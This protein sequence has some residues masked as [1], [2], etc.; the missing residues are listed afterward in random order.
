MR[1]KAPPRIATGRATPSL[2]GWA[3]AR[4][5]TSLRS[6]RKLDCAA[7]CPR[8]S[9][10]FSKS[11]RDVTHAPT[12]ISGQNSP[13]DIT[14][15]A[16]VRPVANLRDM[17]MLDG[18]EMNV[19]DVSLQVG[20][21]A[22]GVLPIPALPNS[23]LPARSLAGAALHLARESPRKSSLDQAPAQR[24]IRIARRQRPNGVKVV[25]QYAN[26]NRLEWL[27]FSNRRVDAP[28]PTDVPNENVARS[29]G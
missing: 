26:R 16:A 20:I 7:P 25:R 2:V 4:T 24:K 5:Q 21:V 13:R 18:I 15:E 10:S 22:N 8:G 28:K 12:P 11:A 17:P 14:M 23:P 1:V 9:R 29:I 27:A 3:K 6:L 19:V